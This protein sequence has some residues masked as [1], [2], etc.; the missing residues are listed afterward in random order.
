MANPKRIWFPHASYHI[1]ARGNRKADIF[2]ADQDRYYYLELLAQNKQSYPFHLH[3][4]CLM[5]N[6]VHL[7]IETINHPPG[8]FMKEIHSNYAMY[9]NKKYDYAGHLFQGPYKADL[10][11]DVNGMLQVSR[12]IHLNP[13]RANISPTPEDYQWSSYTHYISSHPTNTLVTT[14]KLLSY[15]KTQAEYDWFVKLPLKT[16]SSHPEFG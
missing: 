16:T 13:C 4:Y 8:I 1:T 2:Y 12:Y 11:D 15:F 5:T 7:L 6:H 10:Q 9:F 3:A 14:S